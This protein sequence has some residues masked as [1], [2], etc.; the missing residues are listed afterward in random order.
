MSLK[1][2]AYLKRISSNG[3]KLTVWFDREANQIITDLGR[4]NVVNGVAEV[5]IQA[6]SNTELPDQYDGTP[7][8]YDITAN[9]PFKTNVSIFLNGAKRGGVV[10][11]STDADGTA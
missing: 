5:S 6:N 11:Q 8:E 2:H 1:P 10:N 7:V 9:A 4:A 3:Y